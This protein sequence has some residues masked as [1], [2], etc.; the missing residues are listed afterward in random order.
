AVVPPVQVLTLRRMEAFRVAEVN[1]ESGEI[2]PDETPLSMTE[3]RFNE[4]KFVHS[5]IYSVADD[6]KM[7]LKLADW[8]S[9]EELKMLHKDENFCACENVPFRTQ[10]VDI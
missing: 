2:F 3:K 10:L 6:M 1:A 5:V 4:A 9:Y 7:N 8:P